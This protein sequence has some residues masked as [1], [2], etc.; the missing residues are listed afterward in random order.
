[1]QVATAVATNP[2]NITFSVSGTTLT[3]AWPADHTG[4]R[5][6]AQTNHLARGISASPGDWG[7]V[8]G[9]ANTNRVIIPIDQTKPAEFYK[10]VYP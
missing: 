7:T 10:M 9:S 4:W 3:L 5:L 8:T 2:T 1:L 6:L